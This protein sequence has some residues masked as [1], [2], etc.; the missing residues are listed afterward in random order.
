MRML[1]LPPSDVTGYGRAI[2]GRTTGRKYTEPG[3]G[4]SIIR[5][6]GYSWPCILV[7]VTEWQDPK[8]FASKPAEMI[9]STVFMPDG[10]SVPICVI[11]A[12]KDQDKDGARNIRFPL[13]NI[14]PGNPIIARVQGQEYVATVGCLVSD[15]H[16]FFALTNRHVTG[17]EG[18]IVWSELNGV[19][20][21]VGSERQEATHPFAARIDLSGLCVAGH[22]HQSRYRPD[23]SR[24]HFAMDD[25]GPRHRRF[26]PDGGFL[27]H[28]SVA[29][30]WWLPCP[31]CRRR[32]R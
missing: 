21:R 1:P 22:L 29:V 27:G 5:K 15:G 12:P 25:Q 4:G 2:A 17:E 8:D 3:S 16:K 19:Q 26:G 28:Q 31:R 23:R 6:S 18:E 32:E 9:P 24:R 30:S 10:K 14:G 11:E 13:N 20:E 7:F